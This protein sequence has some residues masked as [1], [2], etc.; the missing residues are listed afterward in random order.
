MMMKTKYVKKS[1]V[2][3]KLLAALQDDSA[4]AACLFQKQDLDD[5]IA[6]LS[7]YEMG[8]WKG[9]MRSWKDYFK[10]RKILADDLRELRR[11][12]FE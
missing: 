3:K 11:K 6:A 9:N 7:G 2:G 8:E 4:T 12:A 5:I 1:I 10:R